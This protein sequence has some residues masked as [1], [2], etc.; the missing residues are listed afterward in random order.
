MK[1]L[2]TV[3]ST[4]SFISVFSQSSDDIHNAAETIKKDSLYVTYAKSLDNHT[5][6]RLNNRWGLNDSTKL[7]ERQSAKN[8][9][10]LIQFYKNLKDKNGVSYYDE[11]KKMEIN[12]LKLYMKYVLQKKMTRTLFVSAL[13]ELERT[14]H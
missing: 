13:Q 14:R 8:N 3:I 5:N 4:L 6:D 9:N 1:L 2:I 7:K 11:E 10:S 12:Y